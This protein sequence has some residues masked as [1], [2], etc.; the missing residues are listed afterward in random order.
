MARESFRQRF[1]PPW[2]V[3]EVARGFKVVDAREVVLVSIEC[4]PHQEPSRHLDWMF[5]QVSRRHGLTLARA[6]CRLGARSR[7]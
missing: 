2:S 7:A 5:S 4:S 3:V 6:I 1:P